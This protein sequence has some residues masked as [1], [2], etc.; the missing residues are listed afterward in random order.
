MEA[1]NLCIANNLRDNNDA[2]YIVGEEPDNHLHEF[3]HNKSIYRPPP[4]LPIVP[5]IT[6]LLKMNVKLNVLRIGKYVDP[7]AIFTF[8]IGMVSEGGIIII[9]N[10]DSFKDSLKTII[11]DNNIP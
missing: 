9:N 11:L 4:N 2:I 1:F 6:N 8:Y 3:K 5:F 10:A 7:S